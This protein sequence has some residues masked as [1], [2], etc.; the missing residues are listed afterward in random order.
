MSNR[1]WSIR[2][3][4]P[5][6]AASIIVSVVVTVLGAMLAADRAQNAQAEVTTRIAARTDVADIA[7]LNQRI[8]FENVVSI[9]IPG[10]GDGAKQQIAADLTGI[11]NKVKHLTGL[12]LDSSELASAKE[13]AGAYNTFG[14]WLQT[15]TATTDPTQLAAT[16]KQ[17]TDYVATDTAATSKAQNLL[18]KSL[19]NQQS[20][21]RSAV[22]FSKWLVVGLC[23]V[24]GIVIATSILVIGRQIN[25]R[26]SGVGQ[27]LR[28]IAAGDLTVR[29]P[30]GGQAELAELALN[31]NSVAEQFSRAFV[32]L[33]VTSGLLGGAAVNLES[34]ALEVGRSAEEAS[35]QAGV[36]ARTADEVSQNVQAVAAGG[37]EMGSSIGEISRN[38][39]EAARVATGAVQAVELTTATMSKLGDSSR[40][41]GDV[42]RLITSIAEQTNLLALNA[43]IEA[44]RA[45]DAGKGFAVVADEVKQLAQ[46]TARATED[47]SKRVETIQE[48][49]DQAA[50]SISEVAG[51]ISRI[52][53]FQTTIASA[54]EEQ[55]A[56]TQAINAGV[57]D[58]A[59]GSGQIAR[60]ISGVAD[61]A[62]ATAQ[63]MTKTHDSARELS[64]MSDELAGLVA[65]Y[66]L[67]K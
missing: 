4:F 13:L 65:G 8:Q 62:G 39:N 35:N 23:I 29:V 2:T 18:Q 43:T 47:I 26:L 59:T 24:T 41:I 56:T 36:V 20:T 51:V 53:E 45:G 44:A 16:V 40:E 67:A 5:L 55:T 15:L 6:M 46:E 21:L 60:S 33:G 38:A 28:A 63:S 66:K 9:Y 7:F 25:R 19:I 37:E 48:D 27:G 61:A 58:A 3:L 31:V 57:S 32:S 54:V 10:A 49:A 22:R 11:Q 64:R 1:S 17:Y 52:N 12:P 14:Q 50:R 42:V 30:A 34:I